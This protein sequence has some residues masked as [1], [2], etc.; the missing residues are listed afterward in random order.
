MQTRFY[1]K[2]GKNGQPAA[3]AKCNKKEYCTR[4]HIHRSANKKKMYKTII[5]ARAIREKSGNAPHLQQNQN[6]RAQSSKIKKK[7]SFFQRRRN[8]T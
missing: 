5:V 3:A 2:G 8:E 1:N 6:V 7:K 4:T